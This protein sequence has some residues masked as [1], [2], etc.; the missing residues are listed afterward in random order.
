MTT[1]KIA[2]NVVLT[3][4]RAESSYGIP[5]LVIDGA[6]YGPDEYFRGPLIAALIADAKPDAGM[7]FLFGCESNEQLLLGQDA[8]GR[9]AAVNAFFG[10]GGE[11]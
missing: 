11:S 7:E 10:F 5:V 6:A 8:A 9:K 3:T 2:K 1:I 4:D